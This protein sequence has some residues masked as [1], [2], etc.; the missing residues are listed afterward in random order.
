MFRKLLLAL[1]AVWMFGT[2]GTGLAEAAPKWKGPT[3]TNPDPLFYK[4]HQA[5]ARMDALK[6]WIIEKRW[7][8]RFRKYKGFTYS[9]FESAAP[10]PTAD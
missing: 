1:I 2:A 10:A 3:P 8:W 6:K 7:N 4:H 9:P 5:D